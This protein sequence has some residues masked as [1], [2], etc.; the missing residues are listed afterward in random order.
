MNEE[1]SQEQESAALVEFL[2]TQRLIV[3]DRTDMF[4]R[5]SD[6]HVWLTAPHTKAAFRDGEYKRRDNNVGVIAAE[7]ARIAHAS[8]LLPVTPG[9]QDGNWHE[10]S[11]FRRCLTA[12]LEKNSVIIDI[13]GM[14]DGNSA[15]A[16]IGTAAGASPDWLSHLALRTL[17]QAGISCEIRAHGPLSATG[18]TVTAAY[19]AAGHAAIQIELARRYRDP[20]Q[21]ERLTNAINTIATIATRVRMLT[22]MTQDATHMN[23]EDIPA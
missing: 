12:L 6:P 4:V 7:A 2:R 8:A 5:I 14:Q 3:R 19:N 9:D 22:E 11:R 10:T 15:D 16:I 1:A 13:H 17:T 18:R 21:P 23:P 20:L